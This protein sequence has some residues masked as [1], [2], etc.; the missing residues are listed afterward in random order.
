[1]VQG[2]GDEPGADVGSRG[3]AVRDLAERR[4][5]GAGLAEHRELVV[6][7]LPERPAGGPLDSRGHERGD[8]VERRA[9]GGPPGRVEPAVQPL[10]DE[11]V[12]VAELA[13]RRGRQSNRS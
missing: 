6:G 1:M 5:D 13:L 7:E 2:R 4:A 10:G 8:V 12:V 3:A 11:D 9:D